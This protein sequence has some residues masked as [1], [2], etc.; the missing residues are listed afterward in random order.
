MY[1]FFWIFFCILL[2]SICY[3]NA[4]DI[5]GIGNPNAD[6]KFTVITSGVVSHAHE[7][8]L[9]VALE[10]DSDSSD[11]ECGE[12]YGVIKLSNDVTYKRLK[13]Y[14]NKISI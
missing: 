4:G 7:T 9:T 5:V 6:G 13:K 10:K 11:I 1:I 12:I 8:Y 2:I 3:L 14:V